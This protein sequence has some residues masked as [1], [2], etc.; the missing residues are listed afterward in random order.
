MFW[1]C[2]KATWKKSVNMVPTRHVPWKRWRKCWKT[3]LAV[4]WRWTSTLFSSRTGKCW[5][6]IMKKTL[7][8]IISM[9]S[10]TCQKNHLWLMVTQ[11]NWARLWWVY[12]AMLSM[13]S[14]RRQRRWLQDIPP[15]LFW[16]WASRTIWQQLRYMT[17][18]QVSAR[19][20]STRFSIPSL[21]RR[22]PL[23]LLVWDCT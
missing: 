1:T 16:P 11:N 9:Y 2:W 23:K 20:L 18:E 8:N 3:V 13:P 4:W 10:S 5:W 21:P 22:L 7:Q 14:S 19:A 17:M 15:R 12:W 6:H